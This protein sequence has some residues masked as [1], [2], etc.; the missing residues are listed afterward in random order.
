MARDLIDI[1]QE[2]LDSLNIKL[3]PDELERQLE[4]VL[5]KVSTQTT[6]PTGYQSLKYD[7]PGEG[8]KI[9]DSAKRFVSDEGPVQDFFGNLLWSLQSNVTFGASDIANEISGGA[10]A[11]AYG[12]QPWE[13]ESLWGKVGFTIGEV[14][15][16]LASFAMAKVA[17]KTI[18]G[19]GSAVIPGF[20][21]FVKRTASRQIN[22]KV[23]K[24]LGGTT[25]AA[26]KGVE[27]G[28][29][30]DILGEG[31]KA[32]GE[33]GK[34]TGTRTYSNTVKKFSNEIYGTL[35]TNLSR[36]FKDLD[37]NTIDLLT[38]EIFSKA[39][40]TAPGSLNVAMAS[41]FGSGRMGRW[42]EHALAES[43]LMGLHTTM[44][45]GTSVITAGLYDRKDL[46]DYH[47]SHYVGNMI[48]SMSIGM[49]MPIVRTWKGGKA[50][51][52]SAMGLKRQSGVLADIGRIIPAI[53]K[54]VGAW[55]KNQNPLAQRGAILRMRVADETFLSRL[56][57]HEYDYM[58]LTELRLFAKKRGIS[59]FLNCHGNSEALRR[60]HPKSHEYENLPVPSNNSPDNA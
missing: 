9:A 42:A 4:N 27:K 36:R 47:K 52:A 50:V 53:K 15:G 55:K 57:G 10:L 48:T 12:S 30:D 29:G 1:F 11:N 38:K 28:L 40:K 60:T 17:Q 39:Q 23:A 24:E 13:D 41:I 21:N 32:I 8:D 31:W 2:N 45:T 34:K 7:K 51:E 14:A 20:K 46:A 18:G 5:A 6:S 33:V 35:Q 54:N 44:H 22:S 58:V 56:G 16:V 25:S 49:A 43:T 59:L 26:Y 3:S 19:V 37:S